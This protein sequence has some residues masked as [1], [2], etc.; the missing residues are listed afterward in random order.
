MSTVSPDEP[1]LTLADL[2]EQLGDISP[3]R[4]RA[5]PP[6]GT[7]T[8][9]DVTDIERRENRLYELVDGILVEKI[10]GILESWL[11]CELIKFLGWFLDRHRLG[12][13]AG[14]DGTV[15]LMP[16]LVRIPDVSFISWD[17]VPNREVPTEPIPD[18]APALAVEVLSEGN[19]P[20]EMARKLKEY[21][22]AGV[23]LVWFVD[24]QKRT[25]SVY[26]TPDRYTVLTEEQTLD[27]GVVLPGFALPLRT[28]FAGVPRRSQES[29]P[30]RK[31]RGPAKRPPRKK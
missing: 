15:R 21:F 1:V 17:Q 31:G 10:M 20:K 12:F 13:L 2:L 23:E 27:G 4:I 6:P 28:L 11:A 19:T 26:T 5:D 3:R 22:L 8:E 24:P 25:V 16:G 18:L 14:A 7:A 9:Q 30:Q 29:R